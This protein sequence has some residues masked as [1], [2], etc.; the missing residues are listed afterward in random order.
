MPWYE[1]GRCQLFQWWLID[2]MFPVGLVRVPDTTGQIRNIDESP[3]NQ[4]L[5]SHPFFPLERTSLLFSSHIQFGH[6]GR[7]KDVAACSASCAV[8]A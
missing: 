7:T 2:A 4:P 6:E 5:F 3:R 8:F 1:E